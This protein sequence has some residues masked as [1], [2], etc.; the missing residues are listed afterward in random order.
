MTAPWQAWR[1]PDVRNLAWVLAAPS[2]LRHLPGCPCPVQV[3][4]DA[5]WTTLFTAYR[6]RLDALDHDPG[7]LTAFLAAHPNHRLGYYFEYLLRFWLE[8]AEWHPF[9]LLRHRATLFHGKI[10]VGELDFL[11]R[12]TRTNRVAHWEVA[13]KF[14][15]GHPPLHDPRHWQGPNARDTLGAKLEHLALH[16]FGVTAYDGLVIDERCLLMKGRLFYPPGPAQ[17]VPD[18]LSPNHARG[19]WLDWPRFRADPALRRLRWRHAARDEWLADQQPALQ[20]PLHAPAELTAPD[21][22]RPE[23][24][25]G[26]DDDGR[27]VRRCFLLS[28]P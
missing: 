5:F 7:P 14:F 6:P 17:A 1:H 21:S 18:C 27:E 3:L 23:L 26:F 16:Q 11:V 24:F 20:L 25:I 22:S 10:T 28:E 4:D 19:D 13:V 12:D 9:R 2:L 8:D 15:L